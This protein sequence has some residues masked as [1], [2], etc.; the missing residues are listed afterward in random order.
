LYGRLAARWI[1]PSRDRPCGW[2]RLLSDEAFGVSAEGAVEGDLTGGVDLIGLTVVHLVGRHQADTGMMMVLIVPS[3]E[4][5]AERFGM[6]ATEVPRKLRLV[7]HGFEVAFRER[8][9]VGGVRSAVRVGDTEIDEQQRGGLGAHRT[10]A[11]GLQ[12][13]LAF[14]GRMFIGC[15]L[16]QRGERGALSLSVTHQPTTRRLK[17]SMAT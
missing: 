17:M 4:A 11:I 14:R 13:K 7:F 5:A 12:S 3:E 1:D 6:D 10:A 9:V 8:I 16:E 2:F 15:V